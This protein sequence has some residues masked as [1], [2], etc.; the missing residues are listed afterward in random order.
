VDA[1]R[2][3]ILSGRLRAGSR[4]PASRTLAREHGVA[5]GTV[6]AAFEQLRVEGYVRARTGSGTYVADELPDKLLRV[7]GPALASQ[8]ARARRTPPRRLSQFSARIERPR[9]YQLPKLRAFR[10]NQ[11]AL[12]LFPTT[13]WAQVT[14]RCV[15]RATMDHLTEGTS[16]GWWP[17]RQAVA[18]YLTESRGVVCEA[19][20]VLIVSGTQEAVGLV[21]RALLDPGDA[22]CVEDPGYVGAVRIFEAHGARICPVRVDGDGMVVPSVRMR[23][24]KLAYV[25]PAHQFPLGITMT[26]CRRIDL[27]AWARVSG[28]MVLEDDYD[29]EYRFAGRPVPALQGLDR[30][31]VVLYAGSFSKVLFPGLRLGYLVVP[32]DLV[33]RFS[34]MKSV[35]GQHAPL[36][37]QAVLHEFM[38]EGHF[39]RH[40]RRMREIYAA[41]RCALREAVER[42]LKGLVEVGGI[43]AGL[44]TAAWLAEGID[45]EGVVAAAAE[46]QVEVVPLSRYARRPL[47]RAGLQLGFAAVDEEELERGAMELGRALETVRRSGGQAVKAVRAVG[48]LD[49]R[50][51]KGDFSPPKQG[52]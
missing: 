34:A 12:S 44:Q 50:G 8:E 42:H 24:P 41:R 11:P 31:G 48:P 16:A 15:R 9:S 37:D 21:S 20:Q 4:L 33:D 49:R 14:G 30:R 51:E 43:E 46:R 22:V 23:P 32:P 17:L 45:E 36:L 13:L 28:A 47:P 7:Q 3:E 35:V 1:L 52:P 39:G 19:G 40:V 29:S 6:Q 27:L 25:T 18:D 26:A 10:A 38:V 5:R 2:Q